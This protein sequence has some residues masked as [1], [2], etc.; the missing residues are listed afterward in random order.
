MFLLSFS[1]F[2]DNYFLFI[3]SCTSAVLL[4]IL[5]LEQGNYTRKAFHLLAHS[6]RPLS[7][8]QP[9]S[10]Q[11]TRFFTPPAKPRTPPRG[12]QRHLLGA[13]AETVRSLRLRADPLVSVF[14]S[15][16]PRNA[17]SAFCAHTHQPWKSCL[18]ASPTP[19][20]C[21]SRVRIHNAA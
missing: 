3:F 14:K 4:E 21:R 1:K 11:P 10:L 9:P 19:P 16:N 13:W 17:L 6:K 20:V 15:R 5:F 8:L 7:R 18:A 2:P 12:A